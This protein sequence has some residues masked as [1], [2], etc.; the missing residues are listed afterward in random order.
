MIPDLY[1]E[2]LGRGT[3]APV[4]RRTEARD[5]DGSLCIGKAVGPSVPAIARQLTS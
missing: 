2:L 1:P 5:P 3:A 4:Q